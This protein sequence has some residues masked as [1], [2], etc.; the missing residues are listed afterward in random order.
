MGRNYLS[1]LGR[2]LTRVS[3]R[4]P[5]S[6]HVILISLFSPLM[7]RSQFV[8]RSQ[9]KINSRDDKNILALTF[10]K[11][12][13]LPVLALV[14]LK[15][16]SYTNCS[17]ELLMLKRKYRLDEIFI[18]WYFRKCGNCDFQCNQWWKCCQNNDISVSVNNRSI[19]I[20]CQCLRYDLPSTC[21]SK[22]LPSLGVGT[23]WWFWPMKFPAGQ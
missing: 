12:L 18:T 21:M 23:W 19:S 2:K 11:V 13:F 4:G 15:S 17:H 8:C 1:K 6:S 10:I 7:W 5:W 16:N 9:L 22:A 3:K 20:S 14:V